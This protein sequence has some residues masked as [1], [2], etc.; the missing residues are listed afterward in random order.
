MPSVGSTVSE[1]IQAALAHA[2]RSLEISST[3]RLSGG[4]IHD[5]VEVTLV[6]GE[7][8]VAKM[9]SAA[10]S[11]LFDEE[12]HGLRA[13]AQSNTVLVPQPLAT[14][15][16][17]NAAVLLMTAIQTPRGA[18]SR[19]SPDAWRQFGADLAALHLMPADSRY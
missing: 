14:V 18:G 1:A 17:R 11:A 5:V 15:T 4:C 9:N 8:L 7:K 10:N 13:L 6:S 16:H 2:G 12:A 3:R 19:A